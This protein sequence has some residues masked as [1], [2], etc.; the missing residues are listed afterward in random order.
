MAKL[1]TFVDSGVLIT[2][3]RGQDPLLQARSLS[4]L[5]DPL[6]DFATSAFVRLEVMPKAV[7]A[8]NRTERLFYESF[9]SKASYWL[10]DYAVAIQRAETE[11][12]LY[13]LGSMD[14][15]HIAAAVL[16]N[17]DEFVT[18]EKPTKSIHRT[19]SIKVVSL[20]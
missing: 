5:D 7:W 9:F 19:K 16:L 6:R 2:A 17:A 4:L 18:I 14:A 13:G 12:N 8:N 3:A 1:I 10:D 20:R 11:A 15:L